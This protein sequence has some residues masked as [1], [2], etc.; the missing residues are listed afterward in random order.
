M[1]QQKIRRQKISILQ[2]VAVVLGILVLALAD[3]LLAS[4]L[5]QYV[6]A[7]VGTTVFWGLGA[8]LALFVMRRYILS[9]SYI[10]SSNLIRISYAY[11]KYERV[12]V[13]MYLRNILSCGTLEEMKQRYPKARVN[14]ADLKSCPLETLTVAC[15]DNGQ[16]SLYILQPDDQIRQAIAEA[17]AAKKKK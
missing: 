3:A 11:G 4:V 15:K 13:D 16:P 10:L 12:L 2:G 9:Y 8:L 14:H 7:T 17:A 6:S 1:H 5:V